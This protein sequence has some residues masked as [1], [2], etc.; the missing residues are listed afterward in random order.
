MLLAFVERR[1]SC[2]RKLLEG[3]PVHALTGAARCRVLQ[4]CDV[5]DTVRYNFHVCDMLQS[6]RSK[7]AVP[8]GTRDM[9][10]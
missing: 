6:V 9:L 4:L 10:L 2:V 3:I 1:L 7:S 5:A 8:I